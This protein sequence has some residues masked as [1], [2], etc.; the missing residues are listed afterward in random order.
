MMRNGIL[1]WLSI[2]I[3][4][5][6]NRI[7]H[8]LMFIVIWIFSCI[9]TCS[10]HLPMLL[11]DGLSFTYCFINFF[12]KAYYNP[13]LLIGITRFLLWGLAVSQMSFDE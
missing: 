11:L 3:S 4:A 6:I 8:L 12:F 7:E 2:C 10:H 1:L 9:S 13:L 5:V